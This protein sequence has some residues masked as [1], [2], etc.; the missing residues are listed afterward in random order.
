MARTRS[1]PA[2][3]GKPSKEAPIEPVTSTAKRLPP[4]VTN[5]PKL[6]VLPKDTSKDTRVVTLPNSATGT[7]SRYLF[8]AEKGFYEFTRIGAAKKACKSW[9]IT[10]SLSEGEKEKGNGQ[11]KE[12]EAKKDAEGEMELGS[13]FLAKNPDLF[14][15]TPVDTLFLLLPALS[16]K[17]AKDAKAKQHFLSLDDHLDNLSSTSPHWISLLA[18]FPQL[19]TRIEKRLAVICDTVDAGDEIMYRLSHTKL[20]AVLVK[21]AERMSANGLPASLEDK[22]IKTALEVPIMNV[23]REESALSE[24]T[25]TVVEDAAAATTTTPS[26]NGESQISVSVSS[27][28]SQPSVTTATTTTSVSATVTEELSTPAL[29]TPPSIPPLLRLRTSLTYLSSAYIPGT[30]HPILTPL[31]LDLPIFAPL[32]THLAALTSLKTEALSLRS[33]SDNITRKRNFED[34]DEKVAEREEK[35][36]KKEEDE[37]KRKLESRA[38]KQLK[39]VDTSGMK[40]LSSFFTKAPAKKA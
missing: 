8:C 36:R 11:D 33:I 9:L 28:D 5:A 26:T 31:L 1:K 15:A 37:K 19:R 13:G 38:V 7:P 40:K 30:L 4:A 16:P 22:F 6:F 3:K 25:C 10:S 21:K 14:I 27:M 29:T 35:K 24:T 12:E 34:D 39:K 2:P 32:A 18:Q 20:V 23:K 17:S